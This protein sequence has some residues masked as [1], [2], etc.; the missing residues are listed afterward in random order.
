MAVL[1]PSTLRAG[2]ERLDP[3]IVFADGPDPSVPSRKSA[4]VEF[5]PY[6]Q[7]SARVCLDGRRWELEEVI[8]KDLL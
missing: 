6:E 5:R 8:M 3:G 1:E 2:V 4:W 7:P